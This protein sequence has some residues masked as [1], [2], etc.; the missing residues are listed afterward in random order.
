MAALSERVGARIKILRAQRCPNES[1]R[2]FAKRAGV[3]FTQLSRLE[4]G[5][6]KNVQVDTLERIAQALALPVAA[7]LGDASAA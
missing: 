4:N 1:A 6:S 3:S 7:L 2:S 5:H